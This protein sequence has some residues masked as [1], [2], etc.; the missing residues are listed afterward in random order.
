MQWLIAIY[1][2]PDYSGS[3]G[4]AR[5][6]CS[7]ER[8]TFVIKLNIISFPRV[9][10]LRLFP[11]EY[12]SPRQLPN[13]FS[14]CSRSTLA[15]FF[16]PD[17]HRTIYLNKLIH[18]STGKGIQESLDRQHNFWDFILES[19]KIMWYKSKRMQIICGLKVEIKHHRMHRFEM[20]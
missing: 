15:C 6:V 2:T 10:L 5:V 1:R 9:P 4:A 16:L 12:Y 3:E 13:A 19:R 14:F 20:I 8:T 18:V 7:G 11:D 17:R